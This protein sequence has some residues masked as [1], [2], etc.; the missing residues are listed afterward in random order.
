M[1]EAAMLELLAMLAVDPR[2]AVLFVLLVT[3]AIH[4]VRTYRIPNWLT[5]GGAA[6]GLTYSVF[7]PFPM[8]G[9]FLWA[10]GGLALGLVLMIPMYALKAMG[11]GDVKL[12]AMAGSFLGVHDVIFAVLA[13][14][15]LGGIL[16]LGFALA[17]GV[18][19]SMLGNIKQLLQTMTVSALAGTV[20][21]GQVA[22]DNSVGKLPYGVS[23]CIATIGYV[24]ARQ[25]G[26]L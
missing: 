12:M 10:F 4:D 2:N 16:A 26:F 23:I 21:T 14:F 17:R 7:V 15:I 24:V 20:G 1:N 3:A 18:L 5:L 8:H 25:L 11:A 22:V 6:F 19:G 13:T 9:G